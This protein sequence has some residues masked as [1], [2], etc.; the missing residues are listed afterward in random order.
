MDFNVAWRTEIKAGSINGNRLSFNPAPEGSIPSQGLSFA[1]ESWDSTLS[2][3]NGM[4]GDF[5]FR[6]YRTSGSPS[7]SGRYKMRLVGVTKQ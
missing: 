2:G 5:T 3:V 4:T 7:G 1:I 6:V